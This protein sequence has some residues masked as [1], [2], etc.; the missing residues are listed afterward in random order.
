[1]Q[2]THVTDITVIKQPYKNVDLGLIIK[3]HVIS[4]IMFEER[5]QFKIEFYNKNLEIKSM[6]VQTGIAEVQEQAE[7]LCRSGI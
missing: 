2:I 1:M 6:Y 3:D 5:K 4:A 7:M